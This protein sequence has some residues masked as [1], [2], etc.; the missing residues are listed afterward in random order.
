MGIQAV[1]RYSAFHAGLQTEQH[2]SQLAN[3][4]PAPI[5]TVFGL[6]E[7]IC[8]TQRVK[9]AKYIPLITHQL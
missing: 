6:R 3:I 7:F 9:A 4:P 8:V 2:L 5:S 1:V